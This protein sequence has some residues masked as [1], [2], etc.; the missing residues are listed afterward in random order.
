M[1][2]RMG[3]RV[4]R[5]RAREI[6]LN[7]LEDAERRRMD[8]SELAFEEDLPGGEPDELWRLVSYREFKG[9]RI[10]HVNWFATVEACARH[11][12]WINDG[13]GEVTSMT[14]Y[15]RAKSG[16]GLAR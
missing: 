5:Q 8:T 16:P 13:R 11:A 1:V 4:D 15:V 2:D 9:R 14:K 12:E 7:T 3:T 10:R 6:A